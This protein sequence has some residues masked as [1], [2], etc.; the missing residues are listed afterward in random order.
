[1][2]NEQLLQITHEE[3]M[4][5]TEELRNQYRD[6]HHLEF[7]NKVILGVNQ[8]YKH[9]QIGN[10]HHIVGCIKVRKNKDGI[11]YATRNG[12]GTGKDCYTSKDLIDC[13]D[14]LKG[15]GWGRNVTYK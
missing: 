3:L 14:H 6:A 13:I 9:M 12:Y 10:D 15:Y 4:A 11:F 1:M 7:T 8:G 2:T 5:S